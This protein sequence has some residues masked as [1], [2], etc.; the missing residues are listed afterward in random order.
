MVTAI[1]MRVKNKENTVIIVKLEYKHELSDFPYMQFAKKKNYALL[2][3]SKNSQYC[4]EM[5]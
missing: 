4:S 3:P 5:I 2:Y 1:Y